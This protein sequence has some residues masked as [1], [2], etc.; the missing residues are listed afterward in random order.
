MTSYLGSVL[1]ILIVLSSFSPASLFIDDKSYEAL[2]RHISS[3]HERE[4]RPPTLLLNQ[5]KE[6]MPNMSVVIG[7]VSPNGTQVYNYGNISEENSTN[8]NGD[9]IFDIGSITKTFTTTLLVDM[10]KRGLISLDDPIGR[11]LPDDVKVPTYNGKIITIENLATHNSGLPD[12]PI[13]W[14]RNQSYTNEQVY[15]FLSNI[16]LQSEPGVFANYSD[17]GMGLLGHILAIDSGISYEKL[18]KDR[19]L[20]VLG[21]DSTGIAMNST[22]V[23]YPDILKSR[24]A[25]GHRGG[26]EIGLEFIPEA[27][28]PAGALYSTANDLMKYLSA[29]MGLIKTK[30]NDMLQETHLIRSEY[31]QPPAAR[32]TGELFSSNKSLSTSYVGLGW[33][34][35]TNL[36]TEIIQHSAEI[37][38]YKLSISYI[39]NMHW[40]YQYTLERA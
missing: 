28:Q 11:Y 32:A 23:T 24:L 3:P 37:D 21:M 9:S 29:N 6:F 8:V 25:I 35:D 33:F 18:V 26:Q 22:G 1:L 2:A 30:I 31:Q 17:F 38:G 10:V 40:Y 27:L 7:I 15:N 12:F 36:S 39:I 20:N 4:L 19:I 14:N 16:T 13:G 34:V 5:V